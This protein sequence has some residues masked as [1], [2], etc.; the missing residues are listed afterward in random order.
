[1]PIY[2]YT[3]KTHTQEHAHSMLENP[4]IVCLQCGMKMH[5]KPQA[6]PVNWGGLPPHASHMRSPAVQAM[7]DHADESREH[8]QATS[9]SNP[10]NEFA[11]K[12][13]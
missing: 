4:E 11:T 7:I 13:Y 10:F 12:N 1:M 3:D 8:F 5:R 9:D 6:T 2:V